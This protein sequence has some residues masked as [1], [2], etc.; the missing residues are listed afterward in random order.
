VPATLLASLIARL[1]RLGSAAKET[2]QIGA[3]L[4]REFSY[5]LIEPVAGR[6]WKLVE[7]AEGGDLRR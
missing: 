6:V 7:I 2:A 1:D 5:E 4:G 3:A